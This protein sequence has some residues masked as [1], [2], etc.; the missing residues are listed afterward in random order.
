LTV[1]P[2]FDIEL[3]VTAQLNIR[4]DCRQRDTPHQVGYGTSL[5]AQISMANEEQK[6]RQRSK[7]WSEK[8]CLLLISSYAYVQE[9]KHGFTHPE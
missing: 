2:S 9:T 4:R 5:N 7:G 6:T 8:D 3:N 1:H